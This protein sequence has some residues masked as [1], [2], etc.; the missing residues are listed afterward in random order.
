MQR[1][2]RHHVRDGKRVERRVLARLTKGLNRVFIGMLVASDRE[3]LLATGLSGSAA[4]VSCILE[5][6]VSV[7]KRLT[8]Q[9]EI[10]VKK[11]LQYGK[12]RDK[13]VG[14]HAHNNQ[15]LAFANTIEAIIHGANRV[16]ATML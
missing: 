8:E 2:A 14:M 16:D 12:K 4:K 1:G 5:D 3:L 13:I 15:Q 9:V 11:Y 6:R 7:A 10:L